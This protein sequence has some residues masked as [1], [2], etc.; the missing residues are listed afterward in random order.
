MMHVKVRESRWLS[1]K[2][3][4]GSHLNSHLEKG[5]DE[6]VSLR[7]FERSHRRKEDKGMNSDHTSPIAVQTFQRYG[8]A[9]A[10]GPNVGHLEV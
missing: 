7:Y 3:V 4:R 9:F 1:F 6:R 5:Y 8:S 10:C 2:L